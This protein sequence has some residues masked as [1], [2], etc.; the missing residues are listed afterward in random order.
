MRINWGRGLRRVYFV[1]WGLWGASLLAILV[2]AS[3]TEPN[4]RIRWPALLLLW[5]VVIGYLVPWIL[6]R[7]IEW[8]VA[9]FRADKLDPP[10]IVRAEMAARGSE[11]GDPHVDPRTPVGGGEDA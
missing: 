9:G 5:L 7:L 3:F 1:L 10:P 6:L 4:L 11:V 8:L 2:W